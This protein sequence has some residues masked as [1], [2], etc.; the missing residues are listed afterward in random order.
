MRLPNNYGSISKLSGSRR[1]PFMVRK[2]IGYNADGI[3]VYAYLGCYPTRADALTALS[4]YNQQ[5]KPDAGITLAKVYQA[6][7]P[8]HAKQVGR[9]AL[10]SYKNAYRYI[11]RITSIPLHTITYRHLQTVIDD[12]RSN[13]LSYSS[14]KKVRSLINMLYKFAIINCWIDKEFGQYL[15]LGKDIKVRPHTPFTR[16]QINRLWKLN[17]NT[18]GALILLYTGMRCGELLNLRKKDIKLKSKYL[19]VTESKT[20]AGRNRIIPIHNRIL[21]IIESLVSTSNDRLF[22]FT[23]A[24]F[25]KKFKRL[26]KL[27]NAKHS[28]HDCRHTV[29]SLLDSSGA[30]PNAVRAILGH[31]NGDITTRVYTHKSISDLRKA[32]NLLK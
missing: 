22:P 15:E 6:W 12:M 18:A 29:A 24:Q 27:I 30:N 31:K 23:Y 14:C 4:N 1:N 11:S 26:M 7:L 21:P 8:I 13:G 28:T 9:S 5:V 3:Q 17:E 25:S 2:T 19:I 20:L 32:I 10:D 16:Q